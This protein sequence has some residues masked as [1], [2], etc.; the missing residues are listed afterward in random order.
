MSPENGGE[1]SQ[2]AIS[3]DE[4]LN[5]L[6]FYGKS[7]DDLRQEADKSLAPV[8]PRCPVWTSGR[9]WEIRRADSVLQL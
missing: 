5:T 2:L 7:Y 6:Q 4:T 9:D 1:A 3:Q 8:T